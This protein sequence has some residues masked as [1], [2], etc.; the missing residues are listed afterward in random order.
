MLAVG[1]SALV[2][3]LHLPLLRELIRHGEY[4]RNPLYRSET[5][6][7]L[8]TLAMSDLIIG[9]MLWRWSRMGWRLGRAVKPR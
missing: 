6:P 7:S 1:M 4:F 9:L 5:T 2:V 3:S 8:I